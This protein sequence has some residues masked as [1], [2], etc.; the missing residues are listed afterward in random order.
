VGGS[1]SSCLPGYQ[2]ASKRSNEVCRV[3]CSAAPPA[4]CAG[5]NRGVCDA[6]PNTCGPALFGFELSEGSS[7]ATPMCQ[8]GLCADQRRLV[9]RSPLQCGQ[10]QAGF[11][12]T[13][14]AF[15]DCVEATEATLRAVSYTGAGVAAAVGVLCLVLQ[16]YTHIYT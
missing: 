11:V 13:G 9:C 3:D 6:L 8:T 7:K 1:C 2:H 5:L 12:P 14:D 4:L 15:S 10:C 16:V